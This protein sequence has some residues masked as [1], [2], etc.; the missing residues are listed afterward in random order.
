MQSIKWNEFV[1]LLKE[2]SRQ[3]SVVGFEH[4]FFREL[5][6]VLDER[7]ANVTWYE[8]LLVAKGSK[9]DSCFL[10]AHIDRHG[11]LCTGPNEFQYSAFKVGG[12]SDLLGNS[13]SEEQMNTI[14][15]RFNLE[16]VV[17][18]EP[19]SGAYLGMSYIKKAY[20]CPHR[21]NLIFEVDGLNHLVAGTPI[22]LRN[23]L[24]V[25]KQNQIFTGQLDNILTATMLVHLFSLGFKGTAFFTA[26]E[27]SG[28]SWRY[29]LEWF[30]RFG[31]ETNNL[32]VLDTSP[33][34]E[35][36]QAFNQSVVLRYKDANAIFNKAA[37]ENLENICK[38]ESISYIF[39][40]LYIENLNK[41]KSLGS[42][43]LGR[44]IKASDS[45]VDGTTLQIP[46]IGYHSLEEKASIDA[47]KQFLYLLTKIIKMKK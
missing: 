40:D 22:A 8:G 45:L 42:T 13:V 7:G 18:Y 28:S 6:R 16:P 41:E 20:I 14:A 2:L 44:I 30:K 43:E 4:A 25:D 26:Q 11:L 12:R 15:D 21:N 27:E 46:T 35:N 37:T 39:K 5:Q 10:S 17:A 29:L 36:K 1:D 31:N 47:C 32:I 33:F 38:S 24:K 19:W 23:K 9:P 3:N 34:D